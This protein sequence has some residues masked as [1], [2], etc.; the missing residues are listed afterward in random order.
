MEFMFE[1][2]FN[3]KIKSMLKLIELM[4]SQILMM[5]MIASKESDVIV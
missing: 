2:I 1:T 4:I 3:K 5:M